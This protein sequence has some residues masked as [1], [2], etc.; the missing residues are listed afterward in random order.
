MS[1]GIALQVDRVSTKGSHND[2]RL[3]IGTAR[4]RVSSQDGQAAEVQA[5]W[6][7][8]EGWGITSSDHLAAA[9]RVQDFEPIPEAHIQCSLVRADGGVVHPQAQAASACGGRRPGTAA[10]GRFRARNAGRAV[11]RDN[12]DPP[13]G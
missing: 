12:R 4:L 6:S 5:G 8:I 2:L 1:A 3:R 13:Q 11:R 10:R 9:S 7:R